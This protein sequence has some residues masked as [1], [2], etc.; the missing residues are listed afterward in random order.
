MHKRFN[1]TYIFLS[2]LFS[3]IFGSCRQDI[4]ITDMKAGN[5]GYMTLSVLIADN[6]NLKTRATKPDSIAERAI[7]SL[8]VLIFDNGGNRL[9]QKEKFFKSEL[10]EKGTAG[11]YDSSFS[12][13]FLLSKT[14]SSE[15]SY[16][17]YVLANV[18]SLL[19][20]FNGSVSDLESI[21][22]YDYFTSEGFILSGKEKDASTDV[23][24]TLHR[25]AVKITLQN[26]VENQEDFAIEKLWIYNPAIEC[27]LTAG[28]KYVEN[29]SAAT[30]ICSSNRS[31]AP[32]GSTFNLSE[33]YFEVYINP[34]DAFDEQSNEIISFAVIEAR[35]KGEQTFY[36]LNFHTFDS[37][38]K[39]TYLDLNPN[40]WYE[41][42]INSVTGKG[43]SNID[44]AIANGESDA[45]ITEI[46][47]NDTDVVSM[48]TDGLHELGV[49]GDIEVDVT[50]GN[51]ANEVWLTVRTFGAD[52]GDSE[53][54]SLNTTI[55][56]A[57]LSSIE[58]ENG[59]TVKVDDNCSWIKFTQV[60]V[61]ASESSNGNNFENPGKL[62]NI[63]LSLGNTFDSGTLKGKIIVEWKGLKREINVKYRTQFNPTK[64]LIDET[65]FYMHKGTGASATSK[66]NDPPNCYYISQ[67][68]KFLNEEKVIYC[69]SDNNVSYHDKDSRLV[70]ADSDLTVNGENRNEGFHFPLMNSE[71][72]NWWYEYRIL[73]N[74]SFGN[75]NFRY[76]IE[77]EDDSEVWDNL[78]IRYDIQSN[79]KYT[80][81]KLTKEGITFARGKYIWLRMAT[82][83]AN[84]N[85][86][87]GVDSSDYT[88]AW[89]VITN[90]STGET[91][92]FRLY[93]TGY[94]MH[95]DEKDENGWEKFVYRD[96]FYTPTAKVMK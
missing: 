66:P 15:T 69:F 3:L 63:K 84:S 38:N 23:R 57:G 78:W 29:P 42:H 12:K 39:P 91:Y 51:T 74:S 28:S 61:K 31:N 27:F 96:A 26:D 64:V 46:Y 80:D 44:E 19:D 11:N 89:L 25:T 68:W 86:Y 59:L 85:S 88:M 90:V 75:G 71:N 30:G 62:F 60:E 95:T 24:L 33:N 16:Q 54:P 72:E 8:T 7:S 13:S 76:S 32:R 81:V 9:L 93:H 79:G 36:R 49:S 20:S 21:T 56:S 18:S 34:T 58:F 17:V 6:N 70:W 65:Y 50:A 35:Y 67:Y 52:M 92:R 73:L 87:S 40:H 22:N 45:L 41:M 82:G 94:F 5:D 53:Y 1:L 4:D 48:V 37:Q 83:V 14:A 77:T 10:T 47:D 43:A 55:P 2:L